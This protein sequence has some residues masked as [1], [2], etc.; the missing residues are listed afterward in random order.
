M[1]PVQLSVLLFDQNHSGSLQKSSLFAFLV[2]KF[3]S[4]TMN[5]RFRG[6]FVEDIFLIDLAKSRTKTLIQTN[7]TVISGALLHRRELESQD[8]FHWELECKE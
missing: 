4:T 5:H 3:S 2:Q 8:I 1:F 7:T 6:I